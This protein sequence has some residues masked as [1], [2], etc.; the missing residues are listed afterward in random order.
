MFHAIQHITRYRYSEPIAESQMEV[1]MEPRSELNQRC[2]E[3]ELL[4][5]PKARVHHY[6][7]SIGN[8]VHHFDVP[9]RHTRLTI[10]AQ[11]L[12]EVDPPDALPETLGPDAWGEIDAAAAEGD[13]WE[14]LAPSKF[15]VMS[16][17]LEALAAELELDRRVD[18]LTAL[19]GI[20][21][22]MRST[23][24]Y[25]PKSTRVDT[26]IDDVL[27]SRRGVCQDFSHIMIALVR[28]MGIPCRY[29]SGYLFHGSD[30]R[31]RSSDDATHAWVEAYLPELGWVGLD[32]TND[33]IASD[34]HI[35]VAVG[36]DYADVPPTRGVFRG[37]AD[38]ELSVSVQVV[39]A[40]APILEEP[41]ATSWIHVDNDD[42]SGLV[43]QQQQ[44]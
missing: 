44:Q 26:P 25:A 21:R 16:P 14:M 34:R 40:E 28:Q 1:R 15:V 19:L 39:P 11:S 10:T 42:A 41:A 30:D 23:F 5:T 29:V 8:T 36:R 33:M 38:S 22:A 9:G 7:D 6:R 35:R 12:V 43:E 20:N 2:W 3:F 18:P 32:P 17:L 31:A 13:H 24:A 4:T 27:R 37:S